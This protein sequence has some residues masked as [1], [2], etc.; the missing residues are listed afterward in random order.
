[1]F[2]PVVIHAIEEVHVDFRKTS[3][4]CLTFNRSIWFELR[5]SIRVFYS[6]YLRDFLINLLWVEYLFI[7]LVLFNSLRLID[8]YVNWINICNIHMDFKGFNTWWELFINYIRNCPFNHVSWFEIKSTTSYELKGYF[9]N[10]CIWKS[11]IVVIF[12]FIS[13]TLPLYFNFF[14]W[15]DDSIGEILGNINQSLVFR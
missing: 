15:L 9:L 4:L 5:I 1:M 7:S 6:N 11:V 2:L 13:I 14:F 12:G 8:C 10:N 3:V